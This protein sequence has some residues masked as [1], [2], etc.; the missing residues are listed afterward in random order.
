[1]IASKEALRDRKIFGTARFFVAA[2][3]NRYE[4]AGKLRRPGSARCEDRQMVE[5]DHRCGTF[6][7]IVYADHDA[8]AHIGAEQKSVLAGKGNFRYAGERG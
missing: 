4:H 3:G 2:W 1:M 5:A 6:R 8:V 7:R